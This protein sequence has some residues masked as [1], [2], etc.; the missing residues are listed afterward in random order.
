MRQ[1]QLEISGQEILTKDKAA[2]RLNFYAQYKVVD[3]EKALLDSKDFEKQLYILIQ[4]AL[5]EYVGTQ[6]LDE[7]LDNKKALPHT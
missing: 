7:L 2:L 6:S 4:L 1:L 5:R 3:I